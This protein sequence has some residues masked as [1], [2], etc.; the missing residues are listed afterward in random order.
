MI[1][2]AWAILVNRHTKAR[3]SQ[4]GLLGAVTGTEDLLPVRVK[5]VVR[6]K[7]L[8]WLH[9]L[10]ADLVRKHLYASAPIK[11]ISEWVGAEELYDS[12]VVF[13]LARVAVDTDVEGQ[14]MKIL[15]SEAHSDV[16]R[17][18]ME[19]VAMTD[20]DTLELSLIY[21]AAAPDHGIAS[22]FLQQLKILLEGIACN[23]E[24]TPSALGMRTKTESRDSFWRTMESVVE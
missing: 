3:Y 19:L 13:D 5:T 21:R 14:P 7:I 16:L 4:F 10:Q 18:S 6:L 9:E 1:T 11:T 24:K 23:P 17:P 2:A 15:V 12:V 20:G 8:E 22:V